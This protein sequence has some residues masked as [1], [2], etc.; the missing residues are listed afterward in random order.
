MHA[1]CSEPS[2]IPGHFMISINWYVCKK[3]ESLQTQTTENPSD[4]SHI[5]VC[6]LRRVAVRESPGET[7]IKV[8]LS[9]VNPKKPSFKA[10]Y[11]HH[12]VIILKCSHPPNFTNYFSSGRF[13]LPTCNIFLYCKSIHLMMLEIFRGICGQFVTELSWHFFCLCQIHWQWWRES[14]DPLFKYQYN[15]RKVFHC[16]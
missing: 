13:H 16:K 6:T 3:V 7:I 11:N 8:K 5:E 12:L 10:T 4:W 2:R 9:A 14:S 1:C 15:N